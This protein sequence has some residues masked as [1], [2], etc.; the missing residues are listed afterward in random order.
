M[1]SPTVL[2]RRLGGELRKMRHARKL[3]A[4]QV[5]ESLGWS[6]SKV[7]RIESGKSPL[8]DKDAKLLLKTYGV[9]VSEDVRQFVDLVRRSRQNGWWQSYGD[10]L[11]DW[12]KAYVGFESDASSIQTYQSELVPGLIQT[13]SY[14]FE[15]IRAMN[16]GE[17]LDRVEDRASLR[18]DRQEI[19]N[20]KDP[21]PP[22][23]W[24]ILNE[25]VLRRTVGSGA[26]MSEQLNHLADLVDNHP[27][28]T[29]QILPFDAG[30]HTSMDYSFS[31]LSFSD[32]PGSIV[33]AEAMTSAT[34]LDKA[35]EIA[36]H[37]EVFRRLVAASVQPEKSVSW[38]RETARGF[39]RG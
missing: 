28:V 24:A 29:I 20:R 26:I 34:Y 37:E 8:S 19:L 3:T 4:L 22:R 13:K 32:V 7:S 39:D 1:A 31:I 14:A 35:D 23:L 11:P 27:G 18:F 6:E 30:A 21:A 25:A 33:Y 16:P 38:L 15:V 5:A 17:P 10:A 9:E 36:R 12:F 2:R